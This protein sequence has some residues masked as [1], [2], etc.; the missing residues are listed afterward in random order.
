MMGD[1]RTLWSAVA[2]ML[3]YSIVL[4]SSFCCF[5]NSYPFHVYP[6]SLLSH[7]AMME[8]EVIHFMALFV[9]LYIGAKN[10]QTALFIFQGKQKFEMG[11]A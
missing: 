6:S 9:S 3:G 4:L 8:Y 7:G 1:S 5:F 11:L 10:C 2:L